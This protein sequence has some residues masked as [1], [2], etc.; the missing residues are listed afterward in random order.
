M[1][2]IYP[3]ENIVCITQLKHLDGV[4]DLLKEF[5]YVTYVPD[6]TKEELK[7]TLFETKSKSSYP[8]YGSCILTVIPNA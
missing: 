7:S 3:T 6:I 5:G 8:S 1:K 4:Y 2:T